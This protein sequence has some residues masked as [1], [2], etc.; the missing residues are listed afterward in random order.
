[1]SCKVGPYFDA[2]IAAHPGRERRGSAAASARWWHHRVH[3]CGLHLDHIE[4]HLKLH[5]RLRLTLVRGIEAVQQRQRGGASGFDFRQEV[6]RRR[7][8]RPHCPVRSAPHPGQGRPGVREAPARWRPNTRRS[9]GSAP[10]R[11]TRRCPFAAF[12][13]GSKLQSKKQLCNI[14]VHTAQ[15]ERSVS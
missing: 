4:L 15:P 10:W 12:A 14:V 13:H 8:P 11:S 1:M 7:R 2:W 6:D 9:A 3:S 5:L